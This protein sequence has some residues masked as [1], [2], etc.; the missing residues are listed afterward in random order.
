[1]YQLKYLFTSLKYYDTEYFIP[2]DFTQNFDDQKLNIRE[3]MDMDEFFSLLFD[4]LEN[5]LKGKYL[6]KYFCTIKISDDLTF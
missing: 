2:I 3:Q 4:K 5:R 6:I 1:L